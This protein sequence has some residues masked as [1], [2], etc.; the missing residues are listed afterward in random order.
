MGH[1]ATTPVTLM[2]SSGILPAREAMDELG[3]GFTRHL[4]RCLSSQAQRPSEGTL[5]SPWWI[6][7]Q[8]RRGWDELDADQE[9]RRAV[10]APVTNRSQRGGSSP[11]RRRGV[12][13]SSSAVNPWIRVFF[14]RSTSSSSEAVGEAGVN[15]GGDG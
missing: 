14:L 10:C 4:G 8:R 3:L 1:G 6:G 13:S 7:S 12:A 9:R 2:W 11:D 5:P 15:G